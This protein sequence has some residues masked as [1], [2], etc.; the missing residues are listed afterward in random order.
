M[1][2]WL[3][4]CTS[5]LGQ[6]LLQEFLQAGYTVV[7][8]AR[9][10]EVLSD[11]ATQYPTFFF[12]P[13]DVAD[14][15]SAQRFCEYA[16]AQTG[17]PHLLLNNAATI[18][19]PSALWNLSADAFDQLIQTNVSGVANMIRHTVPLMIE[20]VSQAEGADA[21]S[22]G[23]IVNFSSTW[24]RTTEGRQG[25]YCASKWAIEG[26][27]GSLAQELQVTSQRL[28]AVSLNPGVINTPMLQRVFGE[29]ASGQLSPQAWAS[30]AA[31]YLATLTPH[32]NGQALSVPV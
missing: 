22:Q 17:A 32:Q 28:G 23:M 11:L 26:M 5:G 27:T 7:G 1:I 29:G 13:L 12:C 18:T 30:V 10:Q 21:R 3:T 19:E 2:I 6:A 20:A 14:D 8:G 9:R 31:P 24:G 25:A 16:F 15:G 4:G